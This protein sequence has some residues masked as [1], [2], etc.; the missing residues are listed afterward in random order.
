M[1][2]GIYD[3]PG[4]ASNVTPREVRP[5][6]SGCAFCPISFFFYSQTVVSRFPPLLPVFLLRFRFLLPAPCS[7]RRG[8]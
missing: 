2:A 4:F 5:D 3:L 1:P 6:L 7:R 8:Q